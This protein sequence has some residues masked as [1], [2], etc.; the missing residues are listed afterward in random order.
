MESIFS[1]SCVDLSRATM[2][3]RVIQSAEALRPVLN[4]LSDRFFS[5]A[6]VACD[7]TSVQV[8]KEDGRRAEQK[9]WMLVRST[10][11]EDKKIILFDYS[12]TRTSEAMQELFAGYKGILQTDGLSSYMCLE[13]DSVFHIGCNMHARR[14]FEQAAKDGAETGKSFGSVGMNFYKKIYDLE[15]E[16]KDKT[17]VEK[18]SRRNEVAR[19]L[20]SEYEY[21]TG[22]LSYGKLESDNGF[23][24]RAIRKFAIGRNNW[25]FAD[26]PGGAEAS[27]L[28]Y[29]LVVTAKV[30]G[31]N[32]YHALAKILTDLPLAKTCD[33]Y[34][35]LA[36][37][38]LTPTPAS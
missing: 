22:Y 27:A 30:N 31:V 38:I 28:L 19:P 17:S 9:S 26:T 24:E 6:Y 5:S 15:K 37:I 36:D 20:L 25:M 21:L 8:L 18:E 10:P 1:R 32:I 2:G 4:V 23:T 7:E 3:R 11:G 29:S 35:R 13:S 14:R 12:V 16:L 34:E 33:D